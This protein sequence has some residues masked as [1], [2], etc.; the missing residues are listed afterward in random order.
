MGNCRNVAVALNP[1]TSC[2]Y[3]RSEMILR[4]I[5]VPLDFVMIVL[6]AITAYRVRFGSVIEELRPAIYYL[7][8][9]QFLPLVFISAI[10]LVILCDCRTLSNVRPSSV[11]ARIFQGFFSPHPRAS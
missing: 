8:P 6:A 4:S 1:N 5:L 9:R 3:E 7:P 11:D 2:E 10:L